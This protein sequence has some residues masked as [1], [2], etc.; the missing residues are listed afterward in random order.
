MKAQILSIV[1]GVLFLMSFAP[2]QQVKWEKLGSRK[3]NFGLEKDIIP[4]GVKK[5]GFTKL[6]IVVGG[7]AI[8]MHKMKVNYMNGS[9]EDIALKHTF[10]KKSGSRIIDLKGG[11]RII[12]NIVFFYDTKNLA[13]SRATIHVMGRH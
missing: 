11:K 12:K 13:K 1:L 7:G 3:V 2:S 6:K 5:G 10:T 8:N 4:V 9:R